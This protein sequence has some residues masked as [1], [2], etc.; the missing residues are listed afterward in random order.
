MS[1]YL[2]PANQ[3]AAAIT[4]LPG[5]AILPLTRDDGEIGQYVANNLSPRA[6]QDTAVTNLGGTVFADIATALTNAA[7]S[8]TTRT[9]AATLYQSILVA[10]L[11]SGATA[12]V[13]QLTALQTDLGTVATTYASG[14]TTYTTALAALPAAATG[15]QISTFLKG[16]SAAYLV[17]DNNTAIAL[18][19]DLS[20]TITALI[21]TIKGLG[22]LIAS[23]SGSP[24]IFN[25]P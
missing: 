8:G 20:S 22:N 21:N 11:L 13:T 1:A 17:T 25:G 16:A 15:T 7:G 10:N 18:G 6:G 2:I 5:L 9:S 23:Q 4:A 24:L 3:R 12:L 14:K 19:V